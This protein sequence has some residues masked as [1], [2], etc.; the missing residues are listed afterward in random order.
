M[1]G[2]VT[3]RG[4]DGGSKKPVALVSRDL[5]PSRAGRVETSFRVHRHQ[6]PL[7]QAEL[8]RFLRPKGNPV[9]VVP[10]TAARDT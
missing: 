4:K 9:N 8:E 7:E 3:T 2:I 10:V 6:V 1:R 5:A